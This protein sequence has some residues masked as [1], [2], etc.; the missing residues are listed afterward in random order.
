MTGGGAEILV[1]ML[2]NIQ[3]NLG[4]NITSDIASKMVVSYIQGL[5]DSICRRGKFTNLTVDDFSKAA[6]LYNSDFTSTQLRQQSA[7]RRNSR[8]VALYNSTQVRQ[9]RYNHENEIM[10]NVGFDTTVPLPNYTNTQILEMFANIGNVV[11]SMQS[12]VIKRVTMIFAN[13]IKFD[14]TMAIIAT[15]FESEQSQYMLAY[16]TNH[17]TL[18]GIKFGLGV[19]AFAGAAKV[20]ITL[21][22]V[23]SHSYNQ[24]K[25]PSISATGKQVSV[26][27]DQVPVIVLPPSVKDD[28]VKIDANPRSIS[29][30]R[31]RSR[32]AKR[33]RSR[34]KSRSRSAKRTRRKR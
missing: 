32:S 18:I 5:G 8:V 23:I 2:K 15:F 11:S 16:L 17:Y 25:K 33:T 21:S 29:A 19:L 9:R 20:M 12:D 22:K 10:P 7:L 30:K 34:S 13:Q 1:P 3:S 26:I 6:V 28:D 31:T 27:Q 4:Q 24:G 14:K